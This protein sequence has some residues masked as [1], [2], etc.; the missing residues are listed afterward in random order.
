[1]RRLACATALLALSAC[2]TRAPPKV[3]VIRLDGDVLTY[4]GAIAPKSYAA[5]QAEVGARPVRTLKI[6]SGG[7]AVDEGIAIARWVHRN[8]IDVIV[9]GG[10]F[11]SCA[12]YIFPAGKQK[13][14]VAGGI[15]GW[16]GTIEH[17]LYLHKSGQRSASASTMAAYEKTAAMERAFYAEIGL[18]GYVSWF[19]KI[20]PYHTH[21][22]YFLSQQD[23]EYFGMRG[24]HVRADYLASD[25]S[26]WNARDKRTIALV[27]VDR[28]ITNAQDPN[29][30]APARAE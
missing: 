8:G 3:V 13:H 14:I 6:S 10:C 25:L 24:L 17:L 29:W 20:A 26:R 23:M 5:L 9:D 18:N 7:G 12:N 19:G 15:V 11:S 4:R 22:L 28:A 2:A 16:H 1:V 27:K 30:I 21:N